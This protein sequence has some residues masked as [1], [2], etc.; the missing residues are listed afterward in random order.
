MEKTRKRLERVFLGFFQALSLQ[1]LADLLCIYLTDSGL[2]MFFNCRLI[3]T[4]KAQ[5]KS[6]SGLAGFSCRQAVKNKPLEYRATTPARPS[7]WR[8][9]KRSQERGRGVLVAVCEKPKPGY[10]SAKTKPASLPMSRMPSVM[11]G[12]E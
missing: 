5:R 12:D 6:V 8:L 4:Q 10:S 9:Q 3:T 11:E 1:C 2:R 7:F